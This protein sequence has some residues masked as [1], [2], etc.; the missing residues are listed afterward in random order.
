MY[1]PSNKVIQSG[2]INRSGWQGVTVGRVAVN[3]VRE[4]ECFQLFG[5]VWGA[6][7]VLVSSEASVRQR[8]GSPGTSAVGRLRTRHLACACAVHAFGIALVGW[9]K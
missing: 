2:S 4:R 1:F 9:A 6:N 7:V 3:M 8:A 5:A